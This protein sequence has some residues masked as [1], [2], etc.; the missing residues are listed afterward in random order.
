MYKCVGSCAAVWEHFALCLVLHS[1][2]SICKVALFRGQ[3]SQFFFEISLVGMSFAVQMNRI[4]CLSSLHLRFFA[5][6]SS[7]NPF[8]LTRILRSLHAS[9]LVAI[10]LLYLN[11]VSFSSKL[12]GG[13]VRSRSS[14]PCFANSHLLFSAMSSRLHCSLISFSFGGVNTET[15]PPCLTHAVD[16]L[17]ASFL[18]LCRLSQDVNSSISNRKNKSYFLLPC[19]AWVRR[20]W[21]VF[22]VEKTQFKLRWYLLTISVPAFCGF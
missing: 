1:G 11:W 19:Y 6:C 13:T 9:S 17:C 2:L 8:P 14:I 21:I 4:D 20:C 7:V 22:I 16:A 3:L 18:E 5:S 12:S 15:A 10:R